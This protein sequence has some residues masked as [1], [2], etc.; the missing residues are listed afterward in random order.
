MTITPF[1]IET[2]RLTPRRWRPADAEALSAMHADPDVTAWP[3]VD[4]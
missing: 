2:E 3:D 1:R 4:R